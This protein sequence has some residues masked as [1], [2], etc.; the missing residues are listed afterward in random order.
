MAKKKVDEEPIRRDLLDQLERNGTY[1]EYY[2]DLVN[3]YM[4]I[5]NIAKKLEKDIEKRGVSVEYVSNTGVSNFKKNESI[6]LLLK[7]N[8]QILKLLGQLG[9]K[10]V[11]KE[12]T[13]GEMEDDEL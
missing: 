12:S 11:V 8:A 5:W 4:H 13:G 1:G 2:T 7:T 10:P 3:D 9:I 6:D